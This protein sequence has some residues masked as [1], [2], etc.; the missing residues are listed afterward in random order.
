MRKYFVM[1]KSY[2]V[3][4]GQEVELSP[5]QALRR[6]HVVEKVKRDI[7]IAKHKFDFKSGEIFGYDGKIN[8]K[9]LRQI[10][11]PEEIK[12]E[13]VEEI[14]VEKKDEETGEVS[15]EKEEIVTGIDLDFLQDMS[16]RQLQYYARVKCGGMKLR[17]EMG[18][19]AMIDEITAWHELQQEAENED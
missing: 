10:V 18:K 16:L 17:L 3:Q 11:D 12:A 15:I 1:G 6:Q 13:V 2:T 7:Y 4:E 5:E 8:M 9:L 19:E 14:I